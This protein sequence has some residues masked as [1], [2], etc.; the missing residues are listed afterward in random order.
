MS[1]FEKIT[2]FRE[3]GYVAT[4]SLLSVHDSKLV[5][6]RTVQRFSV[7]VLETPTLADLRERAAALHRG[8]PNTVRVVVGDARVLHGDRENQ[9][10]LFQVASQFNLLEM[11]HP[12]VAPEQGVTRYECDATQGPACAIAAGA[13]TIYRNY[14]V[15]LQG[16]VGQTGQRQID[17][18]PR[19]RC[20]LGERR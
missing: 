20:R 6:A 18:L 7:G 13:A 4:Q 2:G 5:S 11:V 10:A 3:Q 14:L 8:I 12:D 19:P 16:G 9:G 15:P 1:W 17:C